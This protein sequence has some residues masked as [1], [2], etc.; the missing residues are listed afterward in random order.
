MPFKEINVRDIKK[1]PIQLIADDWALVTAGDLNSH[2]TM[3]VSWGGVGE[4]WGKDVS[5]IFIRPQRY[6]LEFINK[7]EFYSVCFFS[8]S[9]NKALK[10]CGAH[11]GRD[12]D[13]DKEANLT[14]TFAEK[15]PF[16]EEANLV[17]ICR[18]MAV[19]DIKPQGFLDSTIDKW[20]PDKDYHK[21]FVGA[22]EK[23]LIKE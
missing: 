15:A 2:N 19:Q 4:L 5:F 7:S 9:K 16:Y 14:A 22:I 21:M 18:K 3:T 6:T 17:L 10:F 12:F 1:S 20:Y 13:K 8:E 23:V 11:S